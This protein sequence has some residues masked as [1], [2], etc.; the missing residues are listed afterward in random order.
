MRFIVVNIDWVVGANSKGPIQSRSHIL[1][2]THLP[3]S[4]LGWIEPIARDAIVCIRHPQHRNNWKQCERSGWA[5]ESRSGWYCR[6]LP[7]GRLHSHTELLG[8][9][10]VSNTLSRPHV[11]FDNQRQDGSQASTNVR[12]HLQPKLVVALNGP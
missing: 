10:D 3:C 2:V 12:L 6:T 9:F 5:T 4:P 8:V 1:I 11:L 7:L